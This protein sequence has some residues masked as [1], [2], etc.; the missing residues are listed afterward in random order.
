MTAIPVRAAARMLGIEGVAGARFA[1]L[2]EPAQIP[3]RRRAI[4]YVHPFAEEMNR[5]RRAA[6]LAARAFAADGWTV[7]QP[8]LLGCGDSS[9]DF[10][11][12]TWDAWIADV[13]AAWRWL[14]EQTG[15]VPAIWGLRAGCLLAT[16]ALARIDAAPALVLWQ[17]ASAGRTHLNQFLRLKV[18]A[19][20]LAAGGAAGGAA[21]L[22]AALGR[23][24]TVVVAGYAVAPALALPL[25]AAEL[26]PP[27]GYDG[28]VLWCES[29]LG[30]PP[31]LAS[32]S[33]KL[34]ARWRAR[35]IDVRETV[36]RGPAFWQTQEIAE[37]PELV[38][39]TRAAIETVAA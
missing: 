17:P 6:A 4:L 25:D 28:P 16:A 36:V 9:G 2:V 18:A 37:C 12:A 7:L 39:A 21:E 14:R 3:A 11:D 23:G 15:C 34:V 27:A 5:T 24:E 35:G 20:A 19:D 13:A 33:A 22:R 8:D 30:Q 31:A 1:Q 32:P 10:G 26:D 29:A 38:A